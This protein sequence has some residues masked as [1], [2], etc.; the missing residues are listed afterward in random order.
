MAALATGEADVVVAGGAEAAITAITMAGFAQART[1]STRNDEPAK[2]S[3][4][5]D[6][7]GTASCSVRAPGSWC[8]SGPSTPRRAAPGSTAGWP[9][10]GTSA[11]GY[12]IT[13]PDPE[14]DGQAR[15]IA[16][17]LRNGGSTRRGRRPRELPRHR[18]PGRDVAET[19]RSPPGDRRPPGA[20]R[21]EELVR[22]SCSARPARSRRSS[23][24]CRC[25]T[26]W[27]GRRST[28]TTW[29]PQVL[30]DVVAGRAPQSA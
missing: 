27:S 13:A 14:G 8:S 10:A 26:V 2:A 7:T 19:A 24:S 15:A 16:A 25:T 11:D 22:A 1:M 18:H 17:A 29:T 5:F 21:A 28:S 9:G 6:T 3:R 4:P 23:P 12:H 20:D 30:L